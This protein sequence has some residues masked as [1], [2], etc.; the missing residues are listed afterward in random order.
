MCGWCKRLLSAAVCF[1]AACAGQST[2]CDLQ[3]AEPA[4]ISFAATVK[5]I[6]ARRCFSCHGPEAENGGLRLHKHETA[7]AE[8]ESG[9]RAI[10]PGRPE[11]SLLLTR[12]SAEDET[13]RMPPKGK[14]L[15]RQEIESLRNWIAQGA[16]WEQHWAFVAPKAQA[17]PA[18]SDATWVRN[19]IDAFIRTKLDAAGLVPAPTADK[20]TLARRAYYDITGLPPTNEQLRAFLRDESPGAWEG[21]PATDGN[22]DAQ[23]ADTSYE[24][25]R[26][27]LERVMRFKC[28][29]SR[30]GA[31]LGRPTNAVNQTSGR[32]NRV[33]TVGF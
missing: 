17:P 12:V 27:R 5:P 11:E 24:L 25:T 19:P 15:T 10:V 31:E 22:S 30:Y 32:G 21:L 8:L 6:L 3:A 4:P 23:I 16:K 7:L 33:L 29:S 18:V 1:L 20:R 9:G 28:E 26:A 13:E 2:R 14:P